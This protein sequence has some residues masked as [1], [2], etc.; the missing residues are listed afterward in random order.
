MGSGRGVVGMREGARDLCGLA[1]PR[2]LGGVQPA[3]GVHSAVGFTPLW[4]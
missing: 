3:V 1:P 4:G 2:H